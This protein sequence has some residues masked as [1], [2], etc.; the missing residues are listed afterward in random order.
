MRRRPQSGRQSRVPIALL[1]SLLI[2]L[3]AISAYQRWAADRVAQILRPVALETMQVGPEPERYEPVMPASLPE[4]EMER[5][6]P[7]KGPARLPDLPSTGRPVPPEASQPPPAVADALSRRGKVALPGMDDTLDLE[8]HIAEGLRRWRVE[9]GRRWLTA[10]PSA[11]TTDQQTRSRRLAEAIVDSAIAAM[12][13]LEL[14]K[15][16]VDKTVQVWNHLGDGKWGKLERRSYWRGLKYR[17]DIRRAVAMG[18]D[19]RRS[20]YSRFG[21]QKPA[22]D[23]R[24]KAERWDFLSQYKGDGILLD[25]VG[26]SGTR[27]RPMHVI[28]VTD[29]AHGGEREVFFD[30]QTHLLAAHREGE[31]LTEYMEY[32]RVGGILLPYEVWVKMGWSLARYRHEIQLDPRLDLALFE[33]PEPRAWSRE[34]VRMVVLERVG[35]DVPDSTLALKISPI[36]QKPRPP[37]SGN[38]PVDGLSLELLN[39]YLLEK[40]KIAGMAAEGDEGRRLEIVIEWYFIARTFP[41]RHKLIVTVRLWSPVDSSWVWS[42]TMEHVW[43]PLEHPAINDETGDSITYQLLAWVGRGLAVLVGQG[44]VAGGDGPEAGR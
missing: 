2:H 8:A 1:A 32:R 19:G 18:Y 25:Y 5:V 36:W 12:G 30:Q 23:L 3:L 35:D 4:V 41:P 31:R 16:V 22:P 40:L 39:T 26:V 13:G 33:A 28:R 14:M 37:G 17:E 42:E 11:D 7:G 20:W 6:K 38:V 15:A 10:L 34:S 43:K 29:M 24:S 9:R 44:Q 21:I 27:A